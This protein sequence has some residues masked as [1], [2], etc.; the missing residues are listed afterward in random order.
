MGYGVP[1]PTKVVIRADSNRIEFKADI[2]RNGVIDTVIYYVGPTSELTITPNPND[3][4]LYRVINKGK[5]MSANLGITRFALKYYDQDLKEV[6]L[7]NAIKIVEVTIAVESPFPL[8][9]PLTKKYEYP[10]AFWKQTRITSRN[11]NR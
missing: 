4:L 8:E 3:R 5:A 6:S 7:V 10:S 9:D 1:D 11:L 2:D